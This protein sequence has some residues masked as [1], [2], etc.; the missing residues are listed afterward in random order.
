MLS[1]VSACI[2][3]NPR[4]HSSQAR[5]GQGVS[6]RHHSTPCS[7]AASLRDPPEGFSSLHLTK[8][9]RHRT[10]RYCWVSF[11]LPLAGLIRSVD[12]G[13]RELAASGATKSQVLV[14]SYHPARRAVYVGTLVL[15][16]ATKYHPGILVCARVCGLYMYAERKRIFEG[17]EKGSWQLGKIF[18]GGVHT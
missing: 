8:K 6:H 11:V 16:L 14:T 5:E 13:D 7:F 18:S 1:S 9:N 17:G 15:R 4:G 10:R 2:K 12:T 3:I